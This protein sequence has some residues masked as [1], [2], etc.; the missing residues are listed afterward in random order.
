VARIELGLPV[1]GV[2]QLRPLPALSRW[3]P[4]HWYALAAALLTIAGLADR[5]VVTIC[6]INLTSAARKRGT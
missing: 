6:G 3:K 2:R 4:W 1:V 5:L